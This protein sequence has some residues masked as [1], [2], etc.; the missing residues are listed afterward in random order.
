M[1]AQSPVGFWS[2]IQ[3]LTSRL[4]LISDDTCLDPMNGTKFPQD[5]KFLRAWC[6]VKIEGQGDGATR[7]RGDRKQIYVPVAPSPC[8]PVALSFCLTRS[9][10]SLI[11]RLEGEIALIPVDYQWWREP[12][13]AYPA[14][15][16]D[17]A[18]FEALHLHFGQRVGVRLFGR[19]VFDQFDADHEALAAHFADDRVFVHQS[20]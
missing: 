4:V 3:G 10:Q 20:S 11:N 15:Q 13:R 6:E 18:A 8:R 7:R 14:A 19:P 9:A 16:R 5:H 2:K 1:R 17:Q 12:D